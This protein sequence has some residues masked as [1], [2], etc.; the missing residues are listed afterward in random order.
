MYKFCCRSDLPVSTLGYFNLIEYIAC[1]GDLDSD[2]P[3][4][5]NGPIIKKRSGP[6]REGG[7]GGGR[8]AEWR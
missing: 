7:Q 5:G 2:L 1:T 4:N 8:E 3:Y 6:G